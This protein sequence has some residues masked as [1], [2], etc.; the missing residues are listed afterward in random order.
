MF[1][2][3]PESA[4]NYLSS[5][6]KDLDEDAGVLGIIWCCS[7]LRSFVLAL[8]AAI[9]TGPNG[10]IF[11]GV[12]LWHLSGIL[13]TPLKMFPLGIVLELIWA[14]SLGW[15]NQARIER[16][17]W[18]NSLKD[19]EKRHEEAME[20]QKEVFKKEL[21]EFDARLGIQ[22]KVNFR[23]QILLHHWSQVIQEKKR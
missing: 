15:L 11:A 12:L 20:A 8:C 21:E 3:P 2:L 10:P 7:T 5:Q 13:P 14:I 4:H 18:N 23:E 16:T 9:E 6:G 1:K 22:K 17:L 19:L